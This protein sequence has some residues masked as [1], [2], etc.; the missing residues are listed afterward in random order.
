MGNQ[1][2][3]MSL[4]RI[5][6]NAGY[7]KEN[8]RWAT[9]VQQIANRAPRKF[10]THKLVGVRYVPVRN[11]WLVF[12]NSKYLGTRESLLGAAALRKSAENQLK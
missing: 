7:S 12:I 11:N 8:C 6:N 2:G 9:D 4:D 10:I 1:P 5:D 3:D